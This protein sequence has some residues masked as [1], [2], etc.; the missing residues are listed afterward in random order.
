MSISA[1]LHPSNFASLD[2]GDITL[3]TPA[4]DI[5]I[6]V[7][8][9]F[10]Q[11]GILMYFTNALAMGYKLVVMAKYDVRLYLKLVDVHRVFILLH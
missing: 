1:D 5:T 6:A 2:C 10:H 7:L 3:T 8:P 4:D 11:Y 9:M